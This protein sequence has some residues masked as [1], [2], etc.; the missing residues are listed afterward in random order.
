MRAQEQQR[1]P[2]ITR[3]QFAIV[4]AL[5][6]TL[7]LNKS[8]FESAWATIGFDTVKDWLFAASL[9]GVVLLVNLFFFSLVSLPFLLKPLGI[10]LLLG[11]ALSAY[12]MDIYGV[13]IDKEM[14]RN[15]METDIN[16]S[17]DL[18]SPRLLAYILVLGI[19]PSLLILRLNIVSG[20][21]GD[22]LLKHV[23]LSVGALVVALLLILALPDYYSSFFRNHKYVRMMQNPLGFINASVSLVQDGMRKPI[24]VE[25]IS[26]GAFLGRGVSA[27]TKPVLAV[28]VVGETA[29]AANFGL[30]GYARDTTPLLKQQDI[31]Y[32]NDFWSCGTSTAVSVPCMFSLLTRKEYTHTKARSLHGLLDF[33]KAAGVGVLWRDNNSGCKG[34]CDRVDYE[35]LD[36]THH[37]DLCHGE[38]CYDEILLRNL[39][40][41]V[42]R[43]HHFIVLHQKGSHGPAYN[44]RYPDAMQVFSPV[45]ATNQLHHCS[46][47][48]LV[49]A[50][51][52]T[53]RYTDYFLDQLINWLTAMEQTHNTLMVYVSDH[54]ESLG[55][56]NM[57][58]HG[59]PYAIAPQYQIHVPFIFWASPGFYTDRGMEQSCVR[60]QKDKTF[61]HDNIF[62]SVLGLLDINTPYY[63]G[64]LDMFRPCL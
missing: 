39:A 37:T 25:P 18:I 24:L 11:G 22:E 56:G 51:D 46:S 20:P 3:R 16:E 34:V 57:Y 13:V 10:A 28:F 32:F 5:V 31:I 17:M 6:F 29:R 52:N 49:N 59:M 54:G 58:L 27:Q 53:I 15:V 50:Y 35:V 45:C 61:S 19:L 14:L 43:G 64:A 47:E 21:V 8:F 33:V 4:L 48:A 63:K 9:V 7:L 12:F 30:G 38:D 1:E 36:P 55:E 44:R 62:H 40:A 42:T 60:Q 23:L 41:K 2:D 26:E